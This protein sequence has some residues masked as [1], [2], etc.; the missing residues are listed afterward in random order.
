METTTTTETTQIA[1][2]QEYSFAVEKQKG[3]PTQPRHYAQDMAIQLGEDPAAFQVRYD[4]SHMINRLRDGVVIELHI[5]RTR[6]SKQS[7]MNDFGVSMGKAAQSVVDK[8]FRMGKRSLFPDTW[9]KRLDTAEANAR[10]ALEKYAFKSPWGLFVPVTRYQDWKDENAK[11]EA[12]FWRVRDEMLEHY[13]EIVEQVVEDHRPL[14]VAAWKNRALTEAVSDEEFDPNSVEGWI[15]RLAQT[16]DRATFITNYLEFIRT[17]IPTREAFA[18]G[19]AYEVER[20]IIPLPSLI[21]ETR[22]RVYQERDEEETRTQAEIEKIESLSLEEQLAEQK[23]YNKLVAERRNQER[24]RRMEQDV[25]ADAQRQK[26]KLVT[27]FY[28][29]VTRQ[30]NEMTASAC[31][32]IISQI[33]KHNGVI[34]GPVSAQLSNLVKNLEGMNFVGDEAIE[35]QL[36][37]LK[38]ALPSEEQKARASKGLAKIDTAPILRVVKAVHEQV[39]QFNVELNTA[40]VQR[41]TREA[42]LSGMIDLGEKRAARHIEETPATVEAV[43]RGRRTF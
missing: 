34:R 30:I 6:G 8:Y 4:M 7:G 41:Q 19:F 1:A 2:E 36:E 24:Q 10:A 21:G 33:E 32:N 20:S 11:R 28:S 16:Q 29:Q 17:L 3:I 35:A 26:E 18:A 39:K 14:A 31:S 23:R 43:R 5:S 25:I 9:R 15:S 12:E 40:P 13:D 27:E 37:R 22:S 42:D 38:A